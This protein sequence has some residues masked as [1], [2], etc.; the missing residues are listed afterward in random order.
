MNNME[1]TL[2]LYGYWH[3]ETYESISLQC[4][5]PM[6]M[7][8]SP[9]ISRQVTRIIKGII[10]I[11]ANAILKLLYLSQYNVHSPMKIKFL[12]SLALHVQQNRRREWR[13]SSTR[14]HS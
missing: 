6:L 14:G 1:S 9:V 10:N 2:V 7:K 4:A 8:I 13:K 5:F 3:I 11:M 12:L